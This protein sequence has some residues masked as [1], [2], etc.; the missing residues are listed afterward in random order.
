ME[1][2]EGIDTF[3]LLHHDVCV[4]TN[5]VSN[6]FKLDF[7]SLVKQQVTPSS[8]RLTKIRGA[9]NNVLPPLFSPYVQ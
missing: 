6:A 2:E 9:G 3:T 8:A 7:I 1:V 5:S 4:S